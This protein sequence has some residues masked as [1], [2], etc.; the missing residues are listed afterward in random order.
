[1]RVTRRGVVSFAVALAAA[2]LVGCGGSSGGSVAESSW[3][4]MPPG[5]ELSDDGQP[6][7]PAVWMDET[8]GRFAVV[9]GGSGSCPTE[10]FELAAESANAVIVRTRSTGGPVCTADMAYFTHELVLP[11]EVTDRPISVTIEHGAWSTTFELAQ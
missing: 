2:S 7:P 4:G 9:T 5:V 10:V 11:T 8:S 3:L 1:M 6:S